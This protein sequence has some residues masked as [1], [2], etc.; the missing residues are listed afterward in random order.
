TRIAYL[1]R[2]SLDLD[3]ARVD[4]IESEDRA[5]DLGAA[6][7]HEAGK[8]HD[9]VR[10]HREGDV[11]ELTGA[12]D[13]VHCEHFLRRSQVQLREHLAQVA[14]HH[15]PDHL[16]GSDPLDVLGLD[17]AAI[18]EDRDAVADLHDLLQTVADV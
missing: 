9:L 5:G 6:G 4:G 2:T 17:V 8:A 10:S 3:A 18:P 7:A 11:L 16:I 14:S 15:E 13:A 12:A 1:D